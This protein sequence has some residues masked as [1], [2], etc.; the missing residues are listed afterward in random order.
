MVLLA[1]AH[2]LLRE[3]APGRVSPEQDS[4]HADAPRSFPG[5]PMVSISPSHLH[6]TYRP[7]E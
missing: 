2:V 7:D 1:M 5:C 6:P 3:Q 4:P